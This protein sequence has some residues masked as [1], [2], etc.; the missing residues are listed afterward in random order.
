MA[1]NKISTY[2][3]SRIL[4]LCAFKE[5]SQYRISRI[6]ELKLVQNRILKID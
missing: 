5:L 3:A 1:R 4:K 2:K 6:H